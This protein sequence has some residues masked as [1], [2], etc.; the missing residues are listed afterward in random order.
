[1]EC[2]HPLLP[3]QS[4]IKS[5]FNVE[6]WAESSGQDSISK[7]DFHFQEMFFTFALPLQPP[8]T[9]LGHWHV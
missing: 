2:G 9:A 6:K 1:M 5:F 8:A 4:S 3:S 7:I